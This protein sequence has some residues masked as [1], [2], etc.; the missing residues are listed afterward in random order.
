MLN[1]QNLSNRIEVLKSKGVK[2]GREYA[3]LKPKRNI[4]IGQ[5]VSAESEITI[6][7][8]ISERF[9]EPGKMQRDMRSPPVNSRYLGLITKYKELFKS[10][11]RN[12]KCQNIQTFFNP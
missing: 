7:E 3:Q 6:A 10:L 2:S 9:S 1:L 11:R 8:L 5:L 4:E 12:N